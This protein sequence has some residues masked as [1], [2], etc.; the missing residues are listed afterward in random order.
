MTSIRGCFSFRAAIVLLAVGMRVVRAEDES[1][2]HDRTAMGPERVTLI[3]R[4]PAQPVVSGRS[5]SVT[6]TIRT[7]ADVTPTTLRGHGS[8]AHPAPAAVQPSHG[9]A[10]GRGHARTNGRTVANGHGRANGAGSDARLDTNGPPTVRAVGHSHA[11]RH[12][13]HR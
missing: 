11:P 7:V 8:A 4:T 2:P 10:V 9:P 1:V 5:S 6:P 3:V 13:A 12:G